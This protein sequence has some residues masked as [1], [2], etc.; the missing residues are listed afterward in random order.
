M[1]AANETL[2]H[3]NLKKVAVVVPHQREGLTAD[4]EIS[5]RHLRRFLGRYDKYLVAPET[6]KFTLPDFT[7]KRFA[8]EFFHDTATYSA[9]LISREF[10]RAFDEYEYILIYQLDALVF[11]DQLAEWCATGL[12]YVGAPWFKGQGVNFV[13]EPAVGNGGLSLRK[14]E[15]FLRVAGAP[16]M[17]T[18][19]DRYW[20][21]LYAAKPVSFRLLNL[22]RKLFRRLRALMSQRGLSVRRSPAGFIDPGQRT[23]E[24]CFWSFRAIR[25]DPSFRIASAADGLRFSF[26]IDPKKCYEL[27]DQHLPF[28]CHAWNKYDREFWEPFLLR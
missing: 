23:N 16:G 2:V 6:L 21:A 3:R 24:D 22:P 8:D 4:E 10:Y 9:L 7:T 14:V 26:E 27:N 25:Y 5:L 1:R 28:G 18:E 19:L 20:D 11:S 17:E 13:D 12:D 15:S